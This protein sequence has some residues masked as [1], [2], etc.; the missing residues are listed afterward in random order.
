MQNERENQQRHQLP[1]IIT[2]WGETGLVI[3]NPSSTS[4]IPTYIFKYLIKKVNKI[5]ITYKGRRMI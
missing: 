3:L 4:G 2:S 5:K 1:N